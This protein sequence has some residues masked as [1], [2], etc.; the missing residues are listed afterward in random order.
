VMRKRLSPY[1]PPLLVFLS[2][3]AAWEFIVRL[4]GIQEFLLPPP[5][6]I[7]AAFVNNLYELQQSAIRTV[8]EAVGGLVIGAS[9][10][11]LIAFAAARWSTANRALMP[12]AIAANSVPTIA[13][14]PIANVWFGSVNPL[15]KMSIVA[16]IVFFPVVINT[17]RGLTLVDPAA[18]ELMRSYAA[19][20]T[21]VFREVRVPNTLPYLFTALKISATLSLISAIIAE[22]FGG[23]RLAL[24]VWILDRA[25]RFQFDEAWAAILVGAALGMLFYLA[26]VLAE[27]RLIPWH[28]SVRTRAGAP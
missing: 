1:L 26:L 24:G 8:L 12:L 13:L 20:E 18:L 19:S 2:V 28:S 23:P 22:Y 10:G 21:D 15:S 7:A 14:A 5:T 11:I 25:R 9:L 16:V 4:S 6:T 27:R 3:I 17:V